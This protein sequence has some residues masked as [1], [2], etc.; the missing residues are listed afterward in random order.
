MRMRTMLATLT[1]ATAAVACGGDDPLLPTQPDVEAMMVRGVDLG[2]SVS[3]YFS[4]CT[5]PAT[6]G[7]NGDWVFP[8]LTGSGACMTADVKGRKGDPADGWILWE[9]CGSGAR[10]ISAEC[11]SGAKQWVPTANP[12]AQLVGGQST[13]RS[14]ISATCNGGLNTIGYRFLYNARGPK[15][16]GSVKGKTTASLSFD[17]T[18]DGTC[19]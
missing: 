19:P 13:T 17:V 16:D 12:W 2:H 8:A 10:G 11:D 18:A 14:Q 6:L 9:I 7:A 15:A 1:A 4:G 5:T 3:Y